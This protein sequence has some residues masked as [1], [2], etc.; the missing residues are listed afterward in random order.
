VMSFVGI[1]FVL[2]FPRRGNVNYTSNSVIN[3]TKETSISVESS[4]FSHTIFLFLHSKETLHF[5]FLLF[6]DDNSGDC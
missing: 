2:N 5:Q 4:I 1:Y 3:I 6:F